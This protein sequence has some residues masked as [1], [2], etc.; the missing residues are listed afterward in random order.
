MVTR[1]VRLTTQEKY[2]Q[3]QV[4]PQV[5][6]R[7]IEAF[8][9]SHGGEVRHTE[10]LELMAHV[11]GFTT[12]K[13]LKAAAQAQAEI[14]PSAAPAI[15][16]KS[17]HMLESPKHVV[18]RQSLAEWDENDERIP[19]AEYDVVVES[20]EG[21]LRLMVKQQGVDNSNFAGTPFLDVMVEI[22]KGVPCAHLHNEP[23]ALL[24]SAFAT[25]AGMYFR[26]EEGD[27]KEAVDARGKMASFVRNVCPEKPGFVVEHDTGRAYGV[28]EAG[29]GAQECGPEC[30]SCNQKTRKLP[31]SHLFVC[32]SCGTLRQAPVHT[33]VSELGLAPGALVLKTAQHVPSTIP[34]MRSRHGVHVELFVGQSVWKDMLYI[35]VSRCFLDGI[36]EGQVVAL[37]TDVTTG[38]HC[39]TGVTTSIAVEDAHLLAKYV[40]QVAAFFQTAGWTPSYIKP[41]LWLIVEDS[42]AIKMAKKVLAAM[43]LHSDRSKCY[44]YL[45]AEYGLPKDPR[46]VD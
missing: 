40:A 36:G 2:M 43:A 6:A 42:E 26:P 8:I 16:P 23:N 44:D 5:A 14:K 33:K 27:L 34:D 4:N 13:A 17:K 45:V 28:S 10:A 1:L 20:F 19:G 25:D 39:Y 18:H 29:K 21:N 12:Y 37:D 30:L 22:Q 35:Q 38:H 7:N 15:P 41:L 24:M 46:S 31:K 9:K 32:D 3:V 11:C